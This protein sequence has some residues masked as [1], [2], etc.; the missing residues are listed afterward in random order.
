MIELR[1]ARLTLRHWHFA[2][3]PDLLDIRSRPDVS[4]WLATPD[5]WTTIDEAL[6]WIHKTTEP[7]D[8]LGEWAVVPDE[9]GRPVGSASLYLTPDEAEFGIGWFLHPDHFG[10][11]YAS[12][13]A[14]AVLGHAWR[15]EVERVW[16][17]M[18]PNNDSS[19]KVASAIGMTDLGVI[20]DPWYGSDQEPTS[21]IFRMDR[22][23][24][25]ALD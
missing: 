19:A 23:T 14:R 7:G 9:V 10:K 20:D 8:T 24:S 22:P 2:D 17:V 12:E 11:G 18:W 4:E 1:T 6:G 21:R 15:A 16:A 5:V 3:A 13:A 25:E